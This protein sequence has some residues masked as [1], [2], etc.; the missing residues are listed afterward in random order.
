MDIFLHKPLWAP[1]FGHYL[2]QLIGSPYEFISLVLF[3]YSRVPNECACTRYL[4][5]TKLP[6]CTLLFRSAAY[7]FFRILKAFLKNRLK[8][9]NFKANLSNIQAK[10]RKVLAKNKIFK[11]WM[12]YSW[13]CTVMRFFVKIPPCTLIRDFRV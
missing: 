8:Q 5:L 6:L 2:E 10:F 4:I 9:E 3:T 13:A 11:V 7:L 12:K 1:S